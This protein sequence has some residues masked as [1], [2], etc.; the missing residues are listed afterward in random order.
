MKSLQSAISDCVFPGAMVA[1]G[2][3]NMLRNPVASSLEIVS[4]GITDLYLVGC[5]LSISGDILVASGSVQRIACG[6]MNFEVFGVPG[7][8]RWAAE[9][10][11]LSIVDQ[12]HHSVLAR[13]AAA[14]SGA[15]FAALPFNSALS[16]QL[17]LVEDFPDEFFILENAPFCSHDVLLASPLRPDVCLLHVQA[18]DE[19]WNLYVDGPQTFDID[20]AL[21]SQCIL[22]TCEE[23]KGSKQCVAAFGK[24]FFSGAYVDRVV[25][26]PGGGRP[27]SVP[28]YYASDNVLA[29]NYI[30]AA[31]GG[32][33]FTNCIK[34]L[35]D[36][37]QLE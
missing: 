19:D 3:Q 13:L 17:R 37:L 7:A 12:D 35:R 34:L 21:S 25:C 14:R 26:V 28:G 30:E 36:A 22:V 27:T 4:Q 10:G 8:M 16:W 5:N 31:K 24:P 9:S 23:I 6:T 2:G 33:A 11:D 1:I 29:N 15:P 18:S 32:E 20:L